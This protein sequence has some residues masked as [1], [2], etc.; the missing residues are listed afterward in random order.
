MGRQFQIPDPSGD[1]AEITGDQVA[2][3]AADDAIG[4]LVAA[5][6]DPEVGMA[7][8]R[9]LP[10]PDS[11]AI[12]AHARLFN[13]PAESLTLRPEAAPGAGV[14]ATFC[15][16]SFAA[17]R[18]QALA[19]VGGFPSG[20]IFGEDAAVAG[21][22]LLAGW[23]KAYVAEACVYHSHDHSLGQQFRRYFDVGVMHARA[24]WLLERFGEAGGEGRRFVQ[25]ELRHLARH[26][27]SAIPS[28]ILRNAIRLAAYHCGRREARIPR[29]VKRRI[30][31]NRRY[32]E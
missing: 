21:R 19:M 10:R 5:F 25:S 18:R 3:P 17:Y 6:A 28:A 1:Q 22:M 16:N 15:S 27:P 30:S 11:S 20:T 8:G 29:P 9:Q 31:L 26:R 4:R 14:K 7:Y 2:L 23:A 13:Y 32:W 24:P 12:G